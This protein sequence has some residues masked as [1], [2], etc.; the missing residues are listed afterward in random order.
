MDWIY[1]I[2]SEKVMIIQDVSLCLAGLAVLIAR[3]FLLVLMPTESLVVVAASGKQLF[4]VRRT[5]DYP[6]IH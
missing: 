4:K 6:L 3:P 2:G 5:E 1:I